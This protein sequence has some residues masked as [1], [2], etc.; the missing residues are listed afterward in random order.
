MTRLK[1]FLQLRKIP[2][3]LR[4]QVITYTVNLY[5]KRSGF[6][7]EHAVLEKLAPGLR[8]AMIDC[9]YSRMLLSVPL[10]RGLGEEV[11]HKMA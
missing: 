5:E 6:M 3:K 11:I 8:A 7:D 2:Q 9:M 10:F 4:D 1:E